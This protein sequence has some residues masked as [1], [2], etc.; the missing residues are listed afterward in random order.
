MMLDHADIDV[1]VEIVEHDDEELMIEKGTTPFLFTVWPLVGDTYYTYDHADEFLNHELC[2][3][4]FIADG[5]ADLNKGS[6]MNIPMTVAA[7]TNT[8]V[9]KLLLAQPTVDINKY[10]EE[11]DENAMNV[12]ARNGDVERMKLL[13]G[14]TRLDVNKAHP[15]TGTTSLITAAA[16][17]NEEVVDLLLKDSLQ[18]LVSFSDDWL[19]CVV[20]FFLCNMNMSTSLP[21]SLVKMIFSFVRPRLDCNKTMQQ[22]IDGRYLTDNRFVNGASALWHAAALGHHE[23]VVRLL[24]Q[25]GIDALQVDSSGKTPLE[26]AKLNGH[27]EC[28]LALNKYFS[29]L[30]YTRAHGRRGLLAVTRSDLEEACNNL[31]ILYKGTESSSVLLSHLD[32]YFKE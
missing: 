15:K 4:M 26:I 2:A 30:V 14:D 7:E 11:S 19:A 12:L 31:F 25:P 27:A 6:D 1:N 8:F 16:H 21:V 3:E 9:L 23:C 10:P 5:R 29:F 13:L 32:D 22:E 17:G 20:S 28:V 24:E 18:D